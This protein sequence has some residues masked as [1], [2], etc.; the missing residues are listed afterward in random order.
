MRYV[1][2]SSG[3]GFAVYDTQWGVPVPRAHC[4]LELAQ[5]IADTLNRREENAKAE[6]P[7]DATGILHG[8]EESQRSGIA[9]SG[10][11]ADS[12]ST[13]PGLHGASGRDHRTVQGRQRL[14]SREL[15]RCH[16]CGQDE[17]EPHL[18]YCDVE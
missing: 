16:G 17:G 13:R 2:Q 8:S 1:V 14:V 6:N 12:V 7:S 3:N 4:D 15:S 11:Q 18:Y 9:P 5:L 10:Q